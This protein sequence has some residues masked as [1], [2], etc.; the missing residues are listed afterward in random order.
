MKP[1]VGVDVDGVLANW[2]EGFRSLLASTTMRSLIPEGFDPPVWDYAPHYGYTAEECKATYARMAASDFF[3]YG[4]APLRGARA[5]ATELSDRE[6][7][8]EIDLYFITQR[9]GLNVKAQTEQWLR[10]FCTRQTVPT[11]LIAAHGKIGIAKDLGLTHFI[12]D[13]RETCVAMATMKPRVSVFMPERA[14]NVGDFYPSGLTMLAKDDYA[15]FVTALDDY[16]AVF[17]EA[18]A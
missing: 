1:I 6:R 3:W 7:S 5:F 10:K 11:V 2:N 15:P 16:I 13:K 18:A 9:V 17:G 12:D 14:Y 8:G 4:L